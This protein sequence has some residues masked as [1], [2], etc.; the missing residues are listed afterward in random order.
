MAAIPPSTSGD[1]LTLCRKSGLFETGQLDAFLTRTPVPPEPTSTARLLVQAGL[2]TN[3]QAKNLLF[4]KYRGLRL[5]QLTLLSQ[6]GQGGMGAV[7]LCQHSGLNRHVAVKFLPEDKAADPDLL[8]RFLREARTAAALDHPNIVR[9]HNFNTSGG[10]HYLV[11]EYIDGTDLEKMVRVQGALDHTL[12]ADYIRQAA[13]GLQHA[14][15]RGLVHRDIKPAN[16]LVDKAGVVKILDFGLAR[17][18]EDAGDR[19]TEKHN[20]GAI[21]GTADFMAPEQIAGADVDIRADIYALGVTFYTLLT[22]RPPFSGTTSQK[23]AAHQQ[24]RAPP[25]FQVQPNV[26]ADIAA[27][28]ERMMAKSPA[29]RYPTPSDVIDAITACDSDISTGAVE[30]TEPIDIHRPAIPAHR[31]LWLGGSVAIV[32]LC[33]LTAWALMPRSKAAS[34]PVPAS[35]NTVQV[36]PSADRS[37]S[38]TQTPSR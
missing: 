14:H 5:G 11:M 1:F 17:S 6:I 15:E 22:G 10:I 28:V 18:I 8:Q 12:A 29:D 9:A 35:N 7:F 20:L 37:P 31:K 3:F 36:Q 16:L 21:L 4:G 23:F 25:L 19:L 27:V 38:P 26:P 33:G 32:V 30:T 34:G 24:F 2:L 13:A